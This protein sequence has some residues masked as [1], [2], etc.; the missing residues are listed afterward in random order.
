VCLG[1]L[2]ISYTAIPIR[3][4]KNVD[5]AKKLARR[6]FPLLLSKCDRGGEKQYLCLNK[7][8]LF[9]LGSLYNRGMGCSKNPD[10]AFKCFQLSALDGLPSSICCLGV[11]YASGIGVTQDLEAAFKLYRQSADLG[12]AVGQFN[13]ASCFRIGVGTSPDYTK[14]VWFYY[15]SAKQGYRPSLTVFLNLVITVSVFFFALLWIL[16]VISIWF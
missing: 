9:I 4:M 11:C 2:C 3:R 5:Q 13:L 1:Y 6:L 10:E 8:E 16:L 7:D 15:L 14:A 12:D